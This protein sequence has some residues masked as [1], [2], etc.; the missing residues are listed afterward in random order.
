[1]F[2]QLIN[3]NYFLS[4]FNAQN[5]DIRSMR[6]TITFIACLLGILQLSAQTDAIVKSPEYA[7]S[8]LAGVINICLKS[9]NS[10]TEEFPV[11][12][13]VLLEKKGATSIK[14]KFP[15]AKKPRTILN[16]RGEKLADLTGIYRIEFPSN[17]S[18][19]KLISQLKGHALIR[20]VEPHFVP[21]LC[22]VPNDTRISEQY[23]LARL[24]AFAAWDLHQGDTAT[25]IGITDTGY[26]PFHP[27]I[28]GNIHKNYNDPINGLDDDADGYIDNFM[29]WDTG[30]NDANPTSDGNYHGQHVSGLSSATTDN[31]TGVAGTG[32]KCRFIHVKVANSDG[33]LTGAYEGVV[34]AADHGCKVI[35]CSWGGTT[36]SQMNEEIIRYAAI[37]MD[38]AVF[39]GAGNNSNEV[40]FYP[41]MYPYAMAVG[42][43][44]NQDLKS[45]FS[46]Y[47]YRLDLFAPGDLVLS[48]WSN[49]EYLSTGGTSMASPTAAGCAALLRSAFPSLSSQQICE[50]LKVTCDSIHQ[51]AGN[52]A[53]YN[54]LGYGRINMFRSLAENAHPSIVLNEVA[55][56]DGNE[57]LFLP[58]DTIQLSGILINYLAA[59]SNV[60]LELSMLDNAF[61]IINPSRSVGALNSLQTINILS[62]PFLIVVGNDVAFNQIIT[63][64][65]KSNADGFIQYQTFS[66][67]V[68]ADFVNVQNN[69]IHTSIGGSSLV[70]VTGNNY[71]PGLGF[72]FQNSPNL[73]YQGGLMLGK[74]ESTVHDNVP[75]DSDWHTSIRLEEMTVPEPGLKM[76]NGWMEANSPSFP[77]ISKVRVLSED[78]APNDHFVIVEYTFKNPSNTPYDQLYAGIFTDWDLPDFSSNRADYQSTLKLGYVYTAPLDT[79]YTG[80]QVLTDDAARQHAIENTGGGTGG[81]DLS[82]GFSNQEKYFCLNDALPQAGQDA[83]GTDV[84]TVVSAGPFSI[85]PGDDH[86]VAFALIAGHS[87]SE[88]T[89][90]AL[91][92]HDYYITT[93]IP[94]SSKTLE[95]ARLKC[96]PNPTDTEFHVQLEGITSKQS[97][98][99][100]FDCRGAQIPVEMNTGS[101][102][103]IQT[104]S[105]PNGIYI[106]RNIS[107]THCI[108]Q[109]IVVRH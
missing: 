77:V 16:E 21:T 78:S 76:F 3:H 25:V 86:V 67:A 79:L 14:K 22:Y 2:R 7:D 45:G 11:V 82:D 92:A 104:S 42:S 105:L 58:G 26:D 32:F 65:L 5:H 68:N 46:N 47:G 39:C 37:N 52:A 102:L 38:C 99:Q 33:Y 23:S 13:R 85:A 61:E 36:Y 88:L 95:S 109:R 50:Q 83:N 66:F 89:Q 44:D 9:S 30:S 94:L 54:K 71:S 101:T 74:D 103:N 10:A 100:L 49:G 59:A 27:D 106:L 6:L 15:S 107:E 8:Y 63:L 18:I 98:W 93:G 24:N 70:G 4:L 1:M 19:P 75:N 17:T 41:A 40:A 31:A 84:L 69:L 80:V 35:N 20:Y 51:I 28:A 56:S 43:T 48:T 60:N 62:E 81:I 87:F 91:N 108:Q 34:Y 72:S 64:R 55:F 96:F 29:G 12:L 57:N 90:A 97:Q 73:L 53:F